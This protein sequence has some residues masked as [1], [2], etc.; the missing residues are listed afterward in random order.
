V[1]SRMGYALTTTTGGVG[2]RAQAAR[3]TS[4]PSPSGRQRSVMTRSGGIR[5]MMYRPAAF[6]PAVSTRWPRRLRRR[7]CVARDPPRRPR[8]GC[9]RRRAR[10]HPTAASRQVLL[11]L[12][13]PRRSAEGNHC[14]DTTTNA[15]RKTVSVMMPTSVSPETALVD[16]VLLTRR[17][18]VFRSMP[19]VLAAA[20]MFPPCRSRRSR[21]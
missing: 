17:C 5:W 7:S 3:T 16:L 4:S 19:A 15:R 9:V 14:S 6:E 18:K 21:R 2:D 8:R 11:A 1:P 20:E 12:G 10:P 13:L